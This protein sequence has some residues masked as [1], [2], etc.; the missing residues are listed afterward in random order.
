MDNPANFTTLLLFF[1]NL[2]VPTVTAAD[3]PSLEKLGAPVKEFFDEKQG[4]NS[5]D[6]NQQK[7]TTC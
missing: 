3:M 4:K 7:P 5:L 1:F 6:K 2:P